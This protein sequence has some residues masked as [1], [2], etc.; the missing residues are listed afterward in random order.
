MYYERE[1]AHIPNCAH[2]VNALLQKSLLDRYQFRYILPNPSVSVLQDT[3]QAGTIPF[4][5]TLVNIKLDTTQSV[6]FSICLTRSN[7]FPLVNTRGIYIYSKR[8]IIL[9]NVY[10]EFY[11]TC[12]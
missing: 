8:R 4:N 5:N 9:A 2:V 7:S 3:T 6:F 12:G 10:F 1:L 11:D